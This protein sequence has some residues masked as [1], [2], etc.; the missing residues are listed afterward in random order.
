MPTNLAGLVLLV[1][2]SLPGYVYY[3]AAD[4][5]L[6]ERLH[7]A[8]QE[9]M[10]IL[11]VSVAIDIAVVTLL[12]CGSALGLWYGPDLPGLLDNPTRYV[13]RNFP[14]MVLWSLA[15]LATAVALA[16]VLGSR[17]W[18]RRL[19]SR[20]TSRWQERS[21]LLEPQKSA[22]WLIFREHPDAV[23]HLGCVLEDGS[24]L[25]GQLHSFSRSPVESGDRDLTLRGDI[26]YR[27]PGDS[28]VA[29]L[30]QVNAVV[31]SARHLVFVTVSYL[32]AETGPADH[33]GDPSQPTGAV[34]ATSGGHA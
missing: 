27:A 14:E 16:Y 6:P 33:H 21:R 4:R 24:Y 1:A 20:W 18:A 3:R 22:W 30:P 34:G 8:F 2:L 23:V 12:G 17:W 31:I 28:T 5:H 29:V 13:I 25:A 7:T 10:S 11:F 19:P 9:L 15:A 26:S 32:P